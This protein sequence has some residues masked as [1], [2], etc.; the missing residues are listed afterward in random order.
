[1]RCPQ[2]GFDAAQGAAFCARCGVRLF[3]PRP[4]AVREYALIRILPSWWRFSRELVLSVLL[5]GGGLYLIIGNRGRLGPGIAVLLLGPIVFGLTALA[6]KF[7]NWSLTSDRL[8]ERRGFLANH[9]REMELADVRSI[10]V[11]RSLKQR[12]L[13]LGDVII[14]SSASAEFLIRMS[15]IPDPERVSEMLRQ[16]RLKRL[17]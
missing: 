10:E 13:G 9:R 3:A 14:A 5:T 17:G 4:D 7:T 8:I 15:D 2:C 16:A 1:M 11:D 6:R 12:I